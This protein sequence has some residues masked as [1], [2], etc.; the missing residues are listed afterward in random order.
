MG[1]SL[2]LD[3]R[4]AI[5]TT[6]VSA[7]SSF[8]ASDAQVIRFGTSLEF[9][10]SDS[11]AE[12]TDESAVVLPC[13][14]GSQLQGPMLLAT[15]KVPSNVPFSDE[16]AL[17]AYY[18]QLESIAVVVDERMTD[19]A[20]NLA[21]SLRLNALFIVKVNSVKKP[22]T[23]DAVA[24]TLSSA[25]INAVTALAGPQSLI[26]ANIDDSFYFYR[27]L[28]N[29]K[30]LDT[31]KLDFGA[32][33]TDIIKSTSVK[34]LLVPKVPRLINLGE[35]STI[36]LPYT[37]QVVKPQDLAQIFEQLSIGKIN[38]MHDDITAAV[39]QLQTLLSQKD[40]QKLSKD[41]VDT[42]SAKIDRAVSP[43]RREY[44]QYVATEFKIDNK[45]S[46]LK[47][48]RM[49]GE[50]RKA[51][52]ETQAVLEPV[53]SSLSNML[54]SQTT[55]KRTHD[56]KRLVRQTQIQNNVEA[57]KSMTF[58]GMTGLLEAHAEEMGVMLVNIETLPYKALLSKLTSREI[59]ARYV[60]PTHTH[61]INNTNTG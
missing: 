24:S 25:N 32:D 29:P 33:I 16:K 13:V 20:R 18:E 49:L 23:A 57:A 6:D 14:F 47:K 39:P 41:L 51:T 10:P 58:E 50:L 27:G 36:V 40:L 15:G 59:D 38:T 45:E 60:L 1:D 5:L 22:D 2:A 3:K 31:S 12:Q 21:T 34:S 17:C 53:I 52:K 44:I 42:L 11:Q 26:V 48:N 56:M 7:I 4:N 55:S 8:L 37:S 19:N 35:D 9:M 43:M 28:S 61:V 46:V 54:S 30:I